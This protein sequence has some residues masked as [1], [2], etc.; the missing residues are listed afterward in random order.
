M[1]GSKKWYQS[2]GM[3]APLLIPIFALLLP[4]IGQA[5]LGA[6]ITEESA[7]ITEWLT[8]LGT[9]IGSALALYGRFRATKEIE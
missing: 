7:G 4:A 6:F 8:A 2:L 9:L 3:W 1:E 5:N